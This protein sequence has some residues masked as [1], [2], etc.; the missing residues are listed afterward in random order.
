MFIVYFN[1]I[2]VFNIIH[3]VSVV[4]VCWFRYNYTRYV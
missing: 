3:G 2:L 1:K 4:M